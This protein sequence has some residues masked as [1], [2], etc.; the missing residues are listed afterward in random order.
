MIYLVESFYSFQGEGK[1]VGSPSIFI[2]L[3]GCN[4]GCVGFGV[5]IDGIVGCDSLKAV[6]ESK[7]S[8]SWQKVDTLVPIIDSYLKGLEFKPDIV[9]TGGEPLLHY[10]NPILLEALEHFKRHRITFET[11]ATIKIEF[12]KYPI[13]KDI[14]FAMSVKLENSGE[15]KAKRLN[16]EAIKAITKN[17]KESFFKF[18]LSR[19]NINTKEI[20]E[21]TKPY[22]NTMI[23]CMPM[24]ATAKELAQNDKSVANFC[25]KNG[26]NYVDRMHIRLWDNEEGR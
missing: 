1:Y 6:H 23:Y 14:T 10:Q 25:T 12:E 16:H 18:V 3:G 5:K 17:T 19:D 20:K 24:G 13:Y 22:P 26:Y 2:R 15:T 7:F 9:F 21:I 4:L 8:H 11:N